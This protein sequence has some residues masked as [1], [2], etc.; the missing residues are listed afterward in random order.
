LA[1]P[2]N[3]Q[4]PVAQGR[5][6]IAGRGG[7]GKTWLL[8]RLYLQILERNSLPIL[9]DL[10]RWSGADYEEWK[11][12]TEF[13]AADATD[14]LLR[15]FSGHSIGV[16]ELDRIAPHLT[17]IVLVDGLN[18]ITSP[19]GEQVLQLLDELARDQINLSVLVADRLIRRSLPNPTAWALGTPL[20]LS[21]EQVQHYL[22]RK[23]PIEPILTCP[24]FLDAALRYGIQGARRAEA[25]RQFLVEHSQVADIELDR[26]ASAAFNAYCRS[27]SRVFDMGEFE[28]E[29]GYHNA[30]ALKQSN[31]LL[32]D[33]AGRAYFAH[34][35]RSVSRC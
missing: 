20:P 32:I 6:I 16:I 5:A 2:H 4:R 12:W 30:V 1:C 28:Q 21:Q 13:D 34:H 7:D 11:K 8:R 35:S 15:K 24:F 31:T 26:V 27:R 10:K 18:E 25:S 29:A 19:V 9:V 33:T 17:K 14:F 3:L 23:G 22:R